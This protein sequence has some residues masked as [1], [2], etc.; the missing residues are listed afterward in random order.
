MAKS[1][2][3]TEKKNSGNSKW[4]WNWF[5]KQV[6]LIIIVTLAILVIIFNILKIVTRH[7]Q[8]LEVHSFIGISIQQATKIAN[9]NHLRLEV[10]DSVHIPRAAKG[11]IFKQNPAAGSHV[12]KNRRIILTI[13]ALSVKQVKMPSLVGYSLRQAQSELSSQ[14]LKVGK[15]IYEEDIA[16]NNVLSQIY[17]GRKIES[18]TMIPTGSEIDLI[19]GLNPEESGAIVPNLKGKPY[20]YI[21]DYLT[22]H[23]LNMGRVVFD[24]GVKT[25]SDSLEAVVYKQEPV[26]GNYERV[27]MGTPVTIW[28]S[29]DKTLLIN[30]DE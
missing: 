20:Q 4:Y 12:K 28:L 16:T 17:N 7:S 11:S 14:Q 5:S 9:E 19:L 27:R 21:K 3:K 29:K 1:K 10:T 26:S 24:R 22:D 30:E 8:E 18:G 25:Y 13:N 23:S 2:T 6:Y 15:L